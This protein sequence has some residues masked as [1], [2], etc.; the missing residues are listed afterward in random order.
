MS[1]SLEYLAEEF[2]VEDLRVRIMYDSDGGDWFNPRENQDNLG[3]MW[4]W[5]PEYVLGDFQFKSEDGRG[6]VEHPVYPGDGDDDHDNEEMYSMADV[7]RWIRNREGGIYIMPLYLYDHS[8]LTIS[9]GD[10][11][12][13]SIPNITARGVNPWDTAG[14]DT[15]AVGFIFTTQKQ[16]DKLGVP[17]RMVER[18]LPIGMGAINV[19][20]HEVEAWLRGEIDEYDSYLRGEIYSFVIER[21]HSAIDPE[22]DNIDCPHDELIESCGGF[23]GDIDYCRAEAKATAEAVLAS[24]KKG[25][26]A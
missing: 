22:C 2:M 5:H 4:C 26:K 14:W 21:P 19:E 17:D 1:R 9:C 11:L 3:I 12:P 16:I 8:G 23:L 7:A 20:M 10:V 6:A 15:S 25:V 24:E 13:E 18:K